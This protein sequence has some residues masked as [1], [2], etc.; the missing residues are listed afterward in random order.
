[1]SQL[2]LVAG[3]AAIRKRQQQAGESRTRNRVTWSVVVDIGTEVAGKQEILKT[4]KKRKKSDPKPTGVTPKPF[5]SY[6]LSK[7]CFF[8]PTQ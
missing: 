2:Y 6:T 7:H 1:M 4:T 3:I 8:S 5:A